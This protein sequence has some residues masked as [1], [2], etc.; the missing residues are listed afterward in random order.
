VTLVNFL[1]EVIHYQNEEGTSN[2]G[3]D[4]QVGAKYPTF[5]Q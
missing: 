3:E 2:I 4:K 1:V 5:F